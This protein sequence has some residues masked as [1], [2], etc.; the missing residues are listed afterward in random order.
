[1]SDRAAPSP[2]E[3]LPG[4]SP[5]AFAAFL[6]Y[7]DL[8]PGRSVVEAYRQRESKAGAKQA[9]GRWNAWAA[10]FDW[11]D[12]VTAY[13]AHM[14]RVRQRA[15]E[16]EAAAYAGEMERRRLQQIEDAWADGE[17][18]RAKARALLDWPLTT[19]RVEGDATIREPSRW[20]FRDVALML[21]LAAELK[22]AAVAAGSR[23]PGEMTDAEIEGT[24]SAGFPDT[25]PLHAGPG[26]PRQDVTEA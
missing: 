9:S 1:M 8:G 4:E 13:D 14:E 25:I 21:R 24:L 3:R 6:A 22:A 16:A 5:R 10:R 11:P 23:P 26:G 2:L 19:E 15:R 17:A 12:R 20:A 7:R 18:L